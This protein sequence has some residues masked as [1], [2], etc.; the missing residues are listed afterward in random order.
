VQSGPVR[1]GSLVV[2]EDRSRPGYEMVKR[3][4]GLPG[5]RVGERALGDDEYWVLGDNLMASTDSRALGPVPR[6]SI[7]GVIR[8]RYW[9]ASRL[10]LLG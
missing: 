3:V 1:D 10:R 2:V 9:P 4:V 8:A 6:S 5:D 7:K